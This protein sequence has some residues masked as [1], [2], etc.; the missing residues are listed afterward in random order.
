LLGLAQAKAKGKTLG[1]PKKTTAFVRTRIMELHASGQ[2]L[3]KIA[4]QSGISK[5]TVHGI[6]KT[7][8]YEQQQMLKKITLE[9]LAGQKK[10]RKGTT[11]DQEGQQ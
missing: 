7:A 1:W 8:Q 6:I 4:V 3:Q 10:V 11:K 5:A 9:F 2:S